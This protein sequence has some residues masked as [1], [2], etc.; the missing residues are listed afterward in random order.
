MLYASGASIGEA[1]SDD[2]L[3]WTRRDG[4]PSTP[5]IDPVLSPSVPAALLA[6]EKPPFDMGQVTDPLLLPRVTPGGRLQIRVLYT[7]YDMAPGRTARS[8][9]IGFAARYGDDGVLTRNPLP[10]FSVNSH[11]MAPALFEWAA[12]SMLYVSLE[13]QGGGASTYP[14]IAAAF[15]PA[16]L[17]LSVPRSYA[18]GP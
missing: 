3:T 14:A 2:G 7:G 17:T 8:S 16:T 12:G 1:A 13:R 6:G 4:D 9:A 11:E 15:A 5:Q 10:V 18:D